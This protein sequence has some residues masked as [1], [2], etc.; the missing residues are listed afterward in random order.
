MNDIVWTKYRLG[1]FIERACL[2]KDERDVLICWVDNK[3]SPTK[4]ATELSMS[5][6]KV[7][8]LR[9]NIRVQYDIVQTE[10]PELFPP[11]E[12]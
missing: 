12:T 9:H 8:R 5:K 2:S 3:Y 7:E 11:R 10:Y 4:T 6:T 1:A